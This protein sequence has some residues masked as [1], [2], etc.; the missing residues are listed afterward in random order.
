MF[1]LVGLD[2][3]GISEA[4][5]EYLNANVVRFG[6]VYIQVDEPGNFYL[7]TYKEKGYFISANRFQRTE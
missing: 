4:S 1:I 2:N 7:C 5:T 6:I 3:R